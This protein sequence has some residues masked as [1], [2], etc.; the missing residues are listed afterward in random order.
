MIENQASF[1]FEDLYI[2]FGKYALHNL[3]NEISANGISIDT[4]TIKKGNAF[5]AFKGENSD[6]HNRVKEAFEKG[7]T[8]AFVSTNWYKLNEESV[9]GLPIITVKNSYWGLGELANYQRNRFDCKIVAV[10][11]S[12]GKTTTKEMIAAVLSTKYKVLKTYKNFNNQ[13]GVPLMLLQLDE[14]Y[15]AA[16]IEIATDSFGEITALTNIV[17]PDHAII[18][19][20]NKEH[21]EQLIDLDGVEMEETNLFNYAK[22]QD[23]YAYIN[24][25]DER[26][27]KYTKALEKCL[28]YGLN[29]E[30]FVRAKVEYNADLYPIMKTKFHEESVELRPN[31]I[32]Y[33][34]VINTLATVAIAFNMNIPTEDIK[35][36]I[37]NYYPD[38][39]TG[40]GRLAVINQNEIKIINDTYNANPGSVSEMIK[41]INSFPAE[42][43]KHII[44]GDM[45]E[46]GENSVQEHKEIIEL[47]E[48]TTTNIY[49]FG[50]EF[51]KAEAKYNYSDKSNLLVELMK[52]LGKGDVVL[53]K[54][55]RGMKM[56]E[57][58]NMILEK[59]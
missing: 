34:G 30:A 26:L 23:I 18:T 57:L 43:N 33:P 8:L 52:K 1:S 20:I 42:I 36:G 12:N 13:L 50:G 55:S 24:L 3:T 19:N 21:L 58:V 56:E 47:A 4:R 6:G 10:A 28:T 15:D 49:T 17:E 39:S 9:K 27:K 41:L 22:K 16:V 25:D 46:L 53:V 59:I 32:G 48:R 45:L 29:N 7:A 37:E 35:K 54:G 40:Y 51:A 38:D 2:L 11:G 5:F 31:V 14:T 44:L